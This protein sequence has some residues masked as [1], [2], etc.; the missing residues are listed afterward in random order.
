MGIFSIVSASMVCGLCI[1]MVSQKMEILRGKK[2]PD[3]AKV[4]SLEEKIK[5]HRFHVENL[6][7]LL[8]LLENDQIDPDQVRCW[9]SC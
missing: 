2:K 4:T 8:R 3:R 6:E 7:Q 9:S 5:Q 1:S